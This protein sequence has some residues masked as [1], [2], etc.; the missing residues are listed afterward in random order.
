[1]RIVERVTACATALVALMLIS[2]PA[3][4]TR[5]TC[6]QLL[7][8]RDAHHSAADIAKAYA[9]T[10]ARVEACSRIERQHERLAAQRDAF[11]ARRADR[12]LAR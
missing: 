6:E 9:T 2:N 11:Y 8:A 3:W 10:Q 12:G 4:A 7:A 1:M 5:P